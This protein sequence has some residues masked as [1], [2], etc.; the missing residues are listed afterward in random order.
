MR[1]SG[2]PAHGWPGNAGSPKAEAAGVFLS[3]DLESARWF[4]RM[5]RRGPVD[6]WAVDLV[7][8]RLTGDPGAGGGDD[9]W[10]I[11]PVPIDPTQLPLIERDV[12]DYF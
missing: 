12:I 9:S 10:M 2:L 11:C 8:I 3:C 7:G 5:G 4:A 6:I 1:T